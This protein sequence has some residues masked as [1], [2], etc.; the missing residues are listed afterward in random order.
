MSKSYCV[1]LG[2]R[3]QS[4][5]WQEPVIALELSARMRHAFSPCTSVAAH[6]MTELRSLH[7]GVLALSLGFTETTQQGLGVS[8]AG[9]GECILVKDD[10]ACYMHT[11]LC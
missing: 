8:C 5:S 3:G 9:K 1:W 2:C 7:R 10:T 11:V 4:E 6:P